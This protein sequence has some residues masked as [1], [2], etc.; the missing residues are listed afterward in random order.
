MNITAHG[1]QV[2]VE[3]QGTGDRDILLLHG[4]G[5]STELMKPV[6]DGFSKRARVTAIDFPGHGRSGRPPVPWGVE[7][8]SRMTVEVLDALDIA[9]CD[10]IG[11][12]HGGRVGLY[13][14][15]TEPT[16]VRRMVAVGASGLRGE[17]TPEQQ[18][19]SARYK[20][21]RGIAD[22]AERLKVFGALPDRLREALVQ[23]Y[24]SAD[25]RV[26]DAE[27]R[28][29]FVRL[30]NYDIAEALPAIQA[31]TLLIWGRGDTETPPWMGERME[32][33]IPDAG[34]VVL[35]GT[36]YLYLERLGDF[37]RIVGHF[38]FEGD[39]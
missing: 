6:M 21:L 18:R 17:P 34:L 4:W 38:L 29:T 36:H 31:P 23:R 16:R 14:A 25:Y 9:S 5:C 20:R 32:K 10:V 1:A 7:D 11:H 33:L 28:R 19:R 15:S 26:L 8:F 30:V 24:G 35:D 22:V 2:Y 13:L 27:M 3:Q 37:L 39:A 12:S